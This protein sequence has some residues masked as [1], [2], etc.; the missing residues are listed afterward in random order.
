MTQV[1]DGPGSPDFLDMIRSGLNRNCNGIARRN[2]LQTGM[3][4]LGGLGL[5][6]V[7]RLRAADSSPSPAAAGK[8]TR[9]VET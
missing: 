1:A 8:D 3:G 6:Q 2:F 7:L 9:G 4:A 5:S